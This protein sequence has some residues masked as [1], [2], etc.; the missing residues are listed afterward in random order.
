MRLFEIMG[1]FIL[2]FL[3]LYRT[4]QILNV[5]FDRTPE[6]AIYEAIT[7]AAESWLGITVVNYTST[8][9]FH[10]EDISGESL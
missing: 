1:F 2:L 8:E 3:S 7:N 4:G 9:S 6:K 10:M 5:A